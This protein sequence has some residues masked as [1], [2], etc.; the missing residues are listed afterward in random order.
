[1]GVRALKNIMLAVMARQEGDAEAFELAA[2]NTIPLEICLTFRGIACLGGMMH[3]KPKLLWKIFI[4]V[5]KMTLALDQWFMVQASHPKATAETIQALTAHPD[6]DLG[7]PNRIRSV[8]GGL[9]SNPVD[10]WSFWCSTTL[11]T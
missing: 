11:L 3:R 1:M 6:Y 7:T 8:S 2:A 9:N 5:L 10:T 4:H